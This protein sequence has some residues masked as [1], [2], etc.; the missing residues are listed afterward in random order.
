MIAY[1]LET[2]RIEA[3]TPR[4]LYLTAYS[5]TLGLSLATPIRDLEHLR[6]VIER[7]FL[8]PELAG[9]MFVAWNGNRFDAFFAAIALITSDE[10]LIRP[11]LTRSNALRGMKV[12]RRADVHDRKAPCWEFVDGISMLGLV[13]TPLAKF[14]ANFAPDHGKL[15]GVID[16]EKEEFDATN[17]RHCDYAMRDSV[18]LWHGMQRAQEIMI[19]R[20][21][22]P[23]RATMGAACI[24]ILKANMPRGVTVWPLDETDRAIV[25]QFVMRG[26]YCYCVRRYHGPVWKYDLN[27]AYAAAMR[28]AI[29][30]A[31]GLSTVSRPPTGLAWIAQ[32]EAHHPTNRVP[33]YYRTLIDGRIKSTFDATNIGETW[34]TS[35]EIEQLQREGWRITFHDIKAW[36]ERFN[37]REYVDKLE[38]MRRTCEGGPSGPIGTMIKAVGNFSYG[39]T[40]EELD[41]V[42]Y[43][44]ARDC[45]SDFEPFYE[46]NDL[47]PVEFLWYREL[48][49]TAAD[50]SLITEERAKDYHQPQIGAFITA[51]VRM[52]V[53]R[54]ALLAPDAWIYADT[55][56]T[57]F[58][59]DVTA[60][61][62][63]DPA[64]YGAWKIE[65]SGTVFRV[66]AK[67][68]YAED[69]AGDAKPKKRS[70]KGISPKKLT[71]DDFARWF[72]GL[73][74]TDTM[75]QGNNFVSVMRG[76]EMYRTQIR[77][78]TAVEIETSA[79]GS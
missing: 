63:I 45:P 19:S 9:S 70:A 13:G 5:G 75:T 68:V 57:I 53:R 52:V 27:Q 38:V 50:G 60:M 31:G 79:E 25:R 1:D 55:D 42:E 8:T 69:V 61:L 77:R 21:N 56:C 67:K 28:E 22:E 20:F 59:R 46:G 3:G 26:G 73:P 66:I 64:R 62:D 78:G 41:P 35:I 11:Y 4:P 17:P 48:T 24:R 32:I 34:L 18:G 36:D 74:P 65:E 51:H 76:A 37:L 2:S 47:I 30:P 23:L 29:L 44:F 6:E 58:T 33:F 14:L 39:K 54:A 16:F 72:D 71:G 12:I 49:R 40:L 7:E 15:V 43:C 10:W